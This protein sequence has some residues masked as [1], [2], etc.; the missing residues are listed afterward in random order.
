MCS[1]IPE[2]ERKA[3]HPIACTYVDCVLDYGHAAAEVKRVGRAS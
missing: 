2:T 3:I 1:L